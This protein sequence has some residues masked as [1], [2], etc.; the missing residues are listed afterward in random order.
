V[1]EGFNPRVG[2]IRRRGVRQAFGTV[3]AH[4]QPPIPGVAEVN[5][6]LDISAIEL[7]DGD[8]E[9]RWVKPGLAFTFRDGGTLSLEYEDRFERLFESAD[10]AGAL[11]PAGDYTFGAT[12]LSYQSSGARLLAGNAALSRGEFYDGDRTSVSASLTFRPSPHLALEAS[13]EHNDLTLAGRSFR[14][15]VFGGRLRYAASTRFFASA[16]VQYVESS[17][18]LV[19]NIRLNYIH[20]PLSDVFVVLT[21]R[22]S[23]AGGGTAERVLT[24]KATRL[25]AF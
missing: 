24:V 25:V 5:P 13:A 11:V 1:G 16:F 17:D 9:T 15:D 3:G 12:S 4:A 7:V 10:I 2:F 14:A 18:E 22:R 19:S 23:L 20:A 8:L 6:F 21:D